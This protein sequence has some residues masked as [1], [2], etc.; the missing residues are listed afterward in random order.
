MKI[1]SFFITIFD[2]N[3]YSAPLN[4]Y[5]RSRSMNRLHMQK[6]EMR[7]RLQETFSSRSTHL[8]FKIV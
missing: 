2:E 3:K 8:V 6:G 1:P 5:T 4:T 7:P